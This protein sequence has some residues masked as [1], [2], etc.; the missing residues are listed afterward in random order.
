MQSGAGFPSFNL[1]MQQ[2]VLDIGLPTGP[3]LDNFFT[4]ANTAVLAHLR[5]QVLSPAR[6]GVPTYLWGE[7]AS[8]KSH[9]LQAVRSDLL[10]R[11][12]LAVGWMDASQLQPP[13]FQED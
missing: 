3:T 5:Q 2:L 10:R 9:L 13:T 8:G 11:D 4:G 1:C 7:S 12:G 6:A